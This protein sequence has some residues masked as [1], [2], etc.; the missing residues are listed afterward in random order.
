MVPME[1]DGTGGEDHLEMDQIHRLILRGL[2]KRVYDQ[3]LINNV[4]RGAYIEHM[5]ELALGEQWG[6]TWPWASWD[7]QHEE[8][9]ARIEIKQ[10]AA[11][12]P[13]HRRRPPESPA[14]PGAYHDGPCGPRGRRAGVRSVP[15]ADARSRASA[16]RR[17]RRPWRCSVASPSLPGWLRRGRVRWLPAN[18]RPRLRRT[19]RADRDHRRSGGDC[20]D[21]ASPGAAGDGPRTLSRPVSPLF[22]AP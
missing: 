17:S 3:P 8:T 16:R 18:G 12:Q 21:P 13:W 14:R 6:L 2:V 10:S 11:R 22:L 4:E 20:A 7:L 15:C 19:P 9:L 5:I 1:P